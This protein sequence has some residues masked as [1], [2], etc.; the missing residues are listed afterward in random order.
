MTSPSD[1]ILAL[2]DRE[3]IKEVVALYSLYILQGQASRIP[4]LFTE[5]GVFR[6]SL[7]L[8]VQGRDDLVAFFSRMP[9][10]V[11]FPIV[12]TTTIT[13]DG[14]TAH[15][16]GVMNNPAYLEGRAGYMGI[17]E[18]R[19]RRIEGR[20]RFSERSFTFVQGEPQP[21]SHN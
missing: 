14:D 6:T 9:P 17:Y 2:E 16:V 15:H 13:L 3:Q 10:G 11:T 5:D 1:R 8:R 4:E 21:V 7:D 18:D 20:W 19:L 12:Q